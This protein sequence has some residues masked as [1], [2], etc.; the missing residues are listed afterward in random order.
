MR[1]IGSISPREHAERF[2]AYLKTEGIDAQIEQENF[3]FEL[4]IKDEDRVNDASEMLQAFRE[5]PEAPKYL[6]AKGLALELLKKEEQ[7][8]QQVQR[9]IVRVA[10]TGA[11]QKK[12]PLTLLLMVISGIVAL[13][14]NFGE[15]HE[16]S[17]FRALAFSAVDNPRSIELL[18]A[19]DRDLD[20]MG[21]RLASVQQ[22]QVW[23]LLTPIFIHHG[24]IHILF[25]MVML[26]QLGRIIEN[27]CGTAFLGIL[28]V[29]SAVISNFFQGVV[30]DN[31]GG[32]I[33]GL[34]E[35]LILINGFGGMSGVV[36]ALFGFM[37]M[38]TL[39]QPSLG[40]NLP[41]STIIILVGWL[42]F[43]MTPMSTEMGVN[44][45]N[46]AHAI[47]LIV[48]IVFGMLPSFSGKS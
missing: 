35:N 12:P 32:S 38:K 3:E 4:W 42:F 20:A 13:F 48:G 15:Y 41:N 10:P 23:R 18:E 43:C 6:R 9:N 45:A 17:V 40:M 8:R 46:W 16:G 19:Y 22:G 2:V 44:V 1:L 24:T 29:A 25:N 27:R 47:G 7:R 33:P 36:Y 5:S 21:I 11:M 34:T 31:V 39:F 14:S 28:V 37:W 26:F 30:P